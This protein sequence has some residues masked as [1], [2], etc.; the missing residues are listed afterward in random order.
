MIPLAHNATIIV[1][2]QQDLNFLQHQTILMPTITDVTEVEDLPDS[3]N[4]S[5]IGKEDA[6][7]FDSL[8][9]DGHDDP[10]SGNWTFNAACTR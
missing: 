7:I 4:I 3:G 9:Q 2:C 10:P 8:H 6:F 5:S 1:P